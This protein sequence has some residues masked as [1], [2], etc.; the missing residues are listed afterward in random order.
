MGAIAI[1]AE[2]RAY[3]RTRKGRLLG[4]TAHFLL[5]TRGDKLVVALSSGDLNAL[6]ALAATAAAG[7]GADALA[8]VVEGVLPLVGENPVTGRSWE[9]GEA[10]HLWLNNDGVDKGWVS[11]AQI[12]A[13]AFR[14]GTTSDEAWPFRVNGGVLSWSREPLGNVRSGL[15]SV[16][17]AHLDGPVMDPAR[18]ADAGDDF[19][20]DPERGPFYDSE[21]GRLVLDIGCTRAIGNQLLGRGEACLIADSAVRADYLVSEGLPSW[22]VEV[23]SGSVE[24]ERAG[25]DG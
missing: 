15:G 3:A 20:A 7:Y 19:V 9:R 4:G 17:A 13:L 25:V 21:Y 6:L 22:Q 12:T 5:A 18:V 16:L 8:L 2:V 11:E 14:D 24:G 10:E 1:S 23:W